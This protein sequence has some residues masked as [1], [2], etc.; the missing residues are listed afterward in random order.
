MRFFFLINLLDIAGN[1]EVRQDIL[2]GVKRVVI[3]IGSSVISNRDKGRSSLECGL[4][5]D[6][7]RHYARKISSIRDMGIDVVLVSSG[8]IMAGRERLEFGRA[9][10]TIPEKQACAAIGQSFLMHTY[11]KA[12]EKKEI[13]VAQILLSHDDLGN[14]KRYLNAKHTI[15]A[16]L[17]KGVIPIINENDS[18]TVE[19]IKIG[20]NDSLSATVACLVDAQLLIILSDVDGLYDR[21][22]SLKSSSGA[23]KAQ[24]LSHV[25]RV[26]EDIEKIAGKSNNRLTVGGM[27]T[28]VLAA[29]KTMSFGIP[30]LVVNG[31]DEKVIEK[32]FT[33]KEVGTLFWSGKGK[34][35]DRKHWIAHTL[36]SAGTLTV[37]AGARKALVEGGKSLLPAGLV[38]VSGN[39]EF[40]NAL[41]LVDESGIEIGRGLVNYNSRDL[42]NIKGMKT[43]AVR[44]LMGKA[45][46]EEVIHR[47][48]LVIF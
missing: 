5:R 26:N 6:W 48:D 18:V 28:K 35:R 39:F 29:K 24:L 14:R 36:K 9:D 22:P 12:F 42:E 15:E 47:D 21:D 40:G 7:V 27:V 20:D 30:A 1:M 45:F 37:D 25:S 17:E 32:I 34:I 44:S 41:T 16:L 33:G 31:L 13:K 38:K 43:S 11:E 4:S 23:E 46:Y 3:K 8:A 10:L 2:K 19:E